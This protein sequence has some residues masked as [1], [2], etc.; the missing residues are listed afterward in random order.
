MGRLFLYDILLFLFYIF[1]ENKNFN[2][3]NVDIVCQTYTLH[4]SF[5]YFYISDNDEPN[6]NFYI[7]HSFLKIAVRKIDV[8]GEKSFRRS[9]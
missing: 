6:N 4:S 1:S 3:N 5:G 8:F 9:S 2:F 7:N